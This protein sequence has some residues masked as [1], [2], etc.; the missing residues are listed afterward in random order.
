MR[1]SPAKSEEV[2]LVDK[3]VMQYS[4]WRLSPV[5]V[6]AKLLRALITADGSSFGFGEVPSAPSTSSS[7]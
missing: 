4:K 7:N 2:T 6:I 1:E 3:N 5:H